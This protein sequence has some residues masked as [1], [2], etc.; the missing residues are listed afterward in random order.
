MSRKFTIFKW[1]VCYCVCENLFLLTY[2]L[3]KLLV[4]KG[5]NGYIFEIPQSLPIKMRFI[6]I[7]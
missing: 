6:Q 2:R 1:L 7:Y 4:T 5:K 3:F